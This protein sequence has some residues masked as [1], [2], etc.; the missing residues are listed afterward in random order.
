MTKSIM[1]HPERS[2]LVSVYIVVI[3]EIDHQRL[4]DVAMHVCRDL[5]INPEDLY[6]K[7]M[8]EIAGELQ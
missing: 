4:T 8:E 2:S 5:K 6:D 3:K 1:R 7:T